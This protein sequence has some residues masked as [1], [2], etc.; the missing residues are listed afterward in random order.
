MNGMTDL[1]RPHPV[2]P[3]IPSNVFP[4]P[5][6]PSS[7]VARAFSPSIHGRMP[8]LLWES[9]ASTASPKLDTRLRGWITMNEELH[10]FALIRKVQQMAGQPGIAEVHHRRLDCAHPRAA[11]IGSI[12]P[13]RSAWPANAVSWPVQPRKGSSRAYGTLVPNMRPLPPERAVFG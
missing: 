9:L 1:A 8:M 2:H 3:V 12:G 13:S 5:V 11:Y 6:A 4:L 10:C 7:E